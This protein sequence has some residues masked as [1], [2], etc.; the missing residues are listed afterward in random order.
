MAGTLGN[1]KVEPVTVSWGG[2]DLGFCDGDI[3]ISFEEQG[4]EVTAH[5]EGANVLSQIRTGKSMEVTVTL[6]ETSVAQLKALF[7]AGGASLTPA[8]VGATE[9][10]GWGSSQDFTPMTDDA[11]KLVLHP[12]VLDAADKARDFA[13]WKA[14]PMLESINFSGENP[15]VVPVTFKVFPDLAKPAAIRLFV[16]GD[17]TQSF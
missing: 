12:V 11:K 3:E 17:H 7:A 2:S 10:S 5:Q 9:V 13:F 8:G 4:V 14:Y 6:K 1:I 16:Q 15:S